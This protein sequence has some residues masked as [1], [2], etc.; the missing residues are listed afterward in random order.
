M[1]KR[2][3]TNY[4]L[5]QKALKLDTKRFAERMQGFT[6]G[7]DHANGDVIS[8]LS[9]ISVEPNTIRIIELQK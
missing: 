6:G 7:E 9:N 5:D 8:N 1:L 3:E 2:L 4:H